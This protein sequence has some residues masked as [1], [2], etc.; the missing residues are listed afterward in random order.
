[1]NSLE[2]VG[3][4]VKWV[5]G[6]F[7]VPILVFLVL[8]SLSQ[9]RMFR[10]PHLRVN[11]LRVLLHLELLGILR[12]PIQ[13]KVL[14]RVLRVAR[15]NL[16]EGVSQHRFKPARVKGGVR[17]VGRVISRGAMYIAGAMFTAVFNPP[18]SL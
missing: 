12:V 7:T 18:I 17:K 9:T 14:N 2:N 10:G 1:M 15:D 16:L 11:A 13:E 8:E 5:T 3:I 6:G 4:V